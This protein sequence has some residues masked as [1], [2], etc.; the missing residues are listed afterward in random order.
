M[1]ISFLLLIGFVFAAV[2][3]A[4]AKDALYA[5]A[6][7]TDITP[8]LDRETVWL[9]GFGA[10]GRKP[11]GVHDPLYA[12][13]LLVS[14]GKTTIALVSVDSLGIY[15]ADVLDMR[16]RLGWEG[17]E[18]RYLFLAATHS[19]SAPD[20]LGL[21]G[22]FPGLSGVDSRYQERLKSSIV[23]LVEG[24]A[25]KLSEVEMRAA[26]STLD[27]VG[28]CRDLR[29]PVVIDPEL[30]V[31]SF[32][33]PKNKTIGTMVRWSCHP[34][35]LGRKNHLF[36]ADYP[37]PLCAKIEKETGGAC[38]FFS[39]V[40]GGL[41]SPDGP[42]AKTEDEV[43]RQFQFAEELGMKVAEAALASLKNA[44]RYL[45]AKLSFKS[46]VVKLQ[47]ENSR[48]TLFLRSLAFGHAL[49]DKEG[50]PLDLWKTYW[51]PLRHLIFFPLP[52]RLRPWVET[53]V[54]LVELGPVRILGVPGELFPELAIGG[55]G[56]EHA[57]GH[58]VVRPTNT[59]PPKLERAPKPPYLRAQMRA[60]HGIIIGI[61][62]DMIGY[63]VPEYDF[64][65]NPNRAM[66]PR[67]EG[68]HY[69]ETNSI[70]KAAAKAL[71]TAMEELLNPPNPT[72]GRR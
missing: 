30:N 71:I 54:S 66:H 68:T 29:D 61:A 7:K 51:Y 58:P 34:E 63:I 72:S 4:A 48:Y 1:K 45:K 56:G 25:G 5:A 60:K 23:E 24:L 39:G 8:D 31:L 67:P 21:W 3:P 11:A 6:G 47:I 10:S 2:S 22:R 57:Y 53:E 70:G 55:Y 40:I 19:H 35:V 14:D 44:D 36:S 26:S 62:N 9:A 50:E 33:T 18:N 43:E 37:G 20:T 38:V 13:A 32:V 69:E 28:L 59:N 42:E 65:F 17:S 27:P 16:R 46:H 41:L 15:R 49:F 64:V 52:E 12:R